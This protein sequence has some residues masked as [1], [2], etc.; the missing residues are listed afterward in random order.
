[1]IPCSVQIVGNRYAKFHFYQLNTINF[2]FHHSFSLQKCDAVDS[3][4]MVYILT[5]INIDS[6]QMMQIP[7]QLL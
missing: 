2:S 5:Q 3:M 6:M 1:M 7:S 4:K